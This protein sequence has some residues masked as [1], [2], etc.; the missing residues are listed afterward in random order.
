MDAEVAQGDGMALMDW[1]TTYLPELV[2]KWPTEL[3]RLMNVCNDEEWLPVMERMQTHPG[4]IVFRGKN[5]G[6]NGLHTA[7][8]RYPPAHVVRAVIHLKP[9]ACEAKNS[10]GETPLHLASYSASE[11]VQ[12]L[13]IS[14]APSTC[15]VANHYGDLPLHFAARNGVTYPLMEL[16]L[17]AAPQTIHVSNN[18]G[19]TPLWLLPRSYLEAEDLEEILGQ[20]YGKNQNQNDHKEDADEFDYIE[21][22]EYLEDW[23]LMVLCLRYAYFG[24]NRQ[25][26]PPSDPQDY[27]WLVHA[28]ASAP[29]CP[30]DVLK[31][32]CRMF[33]EQA[34]QYNEE[35]YTPLL[36]AAQSVEVEEPEEWYEIEDGFRDQVDVHAGALQQQA[37]EGEAQA[38]HEIHGGAIDLDFLQQ[39]QQQQHDTDPAFISDEDESTI[40]SRST[41][42]S[43]ESPHRV[44]NNNGVDGKKHQEP[45]ISIL[46]DCNPRAARIADREG[47]LPLAHALRTGKSW[48]AVHKLLSEYPQALECR[49]RISGMH[50]FQLAAAA[51]LDLENGYDASS[52]HPSIIAPATRIDTVYTMVRGLPQLLVGLARTAKFSSEKKRV[53]PSATVSQTTT[54]EEPVAKRTKVSS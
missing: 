37:P 31:F 10:S 12:E 39:Q 13:L 35:G 20:N 48:P 33:P 19:V 14:A 36:L 6:M 22:Q 24:S 21:D 11:E 53:A 29:S 46:L 41:G 30:R 47:R 7:C 17:S 1:Q 42:S 16:L 26:K 38:L 44:V 32:L 3:M 18:R 27:S 54:I 49:D 5:D 34:L 50:M 40:R 8:L 25:R 9:E 23:N 4:E 45:V 28:A 43:C 51:D 52:S 2:R 15:A